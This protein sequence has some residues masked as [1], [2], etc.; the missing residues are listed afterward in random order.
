MRIGSLNAPAAQSDRFRE[1]R[2]QTGWLLPD[3]VE[4][5]FDAYLKCGRLE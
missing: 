5:E 2:A 3:Y 4:A 1:L